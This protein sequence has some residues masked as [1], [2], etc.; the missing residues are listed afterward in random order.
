M[1]PAQHKRPLDITHMHQHPCRNV[2]LRRIAEGVVDVGA[3]VLDGTAVEVAVTVDMQVRAQSR[4]PV[5]QPAGT[6]D[7]IKEAV[8]LR[9]TLRHQVDA[10]QEMRERQDR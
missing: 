4:D 1:D 2:A 7:G 3:P 8:F 5:F 10:W 6:K 9:H